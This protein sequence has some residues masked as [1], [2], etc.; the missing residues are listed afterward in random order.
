MANL[1]GQIVYAINKCFTEGTD[2]HNYKEENG[3]GMSHKIFSYEEKYR[4]K[5][6]ARNFTN[7]LKHENIQVKQIKDIKAE[8]VQSFLNSKLHCTQNTVN[9]YASSLFKIQYVVNKVYPSCDV[10][11]RGEIAI[12]IVE[13][14]SATNRGSDSVITRGDYNKILSYVKDNPSQSGYALQIQDFLGIRVEELARI[15][16]SNIDLEKGVIRL[17]NTKGGKVI[18]K[19]IPAD[20]VKLIKEI[21]NEHYHKDKLF[22]IEGASINRYLNRIEDKLNIDRHSNHDIRRL[23]AQ[24]KYDNYRKNGLN[25]REAVNATSKW[26]S[27]GD[28]RKNMIEKSYI[29]IW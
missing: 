14:R 13:R 10:K 23:L 8:H 3:K 21:I 27:H 4:L 6:V 17:D 5:D 1:Y 22:S 24:E 2:K 19:E 25:Q 15:K 28:D 26:L 18:V 12:P 29:K 16:L 9:S 7:Y 20:K 11:W